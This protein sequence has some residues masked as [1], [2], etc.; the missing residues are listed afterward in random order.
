MLE[1]AVIRDHTT[2]IRHI[3]YTGI[4]S[5]TFLVTELELA[6]NKLR[7]V[8]LEKVFM[9]Q[10]QISV[11]IVYKEAVS[12]TSNRLFFKITVSS[13]TCIFHLKQSTRVT[14]KKQDASL[15]SVYACHSS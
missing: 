5:S 6:I 8:L 2:A 7:S 3:S 9:G 11:R 14:T 4:K 10:K 15:C 1:L 12:K 13:Q